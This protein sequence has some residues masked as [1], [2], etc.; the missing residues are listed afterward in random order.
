MDTFIAREE[1]LGW[2]DDTNHFLDMHQQY[3]DSWKEKK[4]W[5]IDIETDH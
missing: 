4:E 1:V 3:I 5:M 2:F